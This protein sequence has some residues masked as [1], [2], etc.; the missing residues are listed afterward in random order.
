MGLVNEKNINL[1]IV[2]KG[3]FIY[4]D[5]YSYFEILFP[6]EEYI[7]ENILNNNSLVAKFISK[8]TSVLFTGDIEE[9]S[10]DRLCELYGT[11]NKLEADILKVAHHGSK[12]SSTEDFLGLVNP[13]IVLIG[14]SEGNNFGHPNSNVI[15]RLKK[16][17]NLIYR[18]DKNVEIEIKI[19]N[20]EVEV[21]TMLNE[22]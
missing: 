5:R 11:T 13:K 20:N 10:E 7:L 9:T 16:Y 19:N 6:E 3:D 2:K 18:T 8:N 15:E 4:I 1:I 22:K 14:V 21:N 12:T 17:T